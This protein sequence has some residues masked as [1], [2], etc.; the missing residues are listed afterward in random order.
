MVKQINSVQDV[1]DFLATVS[2]QLAEQC[3]LEFEAVWNDVAELD[4][5]E[6]EAGSTRT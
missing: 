4:E 1:L 6:S 3:A 2:P 5:T